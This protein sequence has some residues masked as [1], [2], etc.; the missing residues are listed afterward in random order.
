[1]RC[2]F[3]G[4]HARRVHFTHAFGICIAAAA[5][6]AFGNKPRVHENCFRAYLH[7]AMFPFLMIA[8]QLAHGMAVACWA[9]LL[10]FIRMHWLRIFFL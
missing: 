10:A 1:M 8:T 7:V 6:A 2:A 3:A 9:V 4:M 5:A